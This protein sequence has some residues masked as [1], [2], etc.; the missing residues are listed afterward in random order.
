MV[1]LRRLVSSQAIKAGHGTI[2]ATPEAD[3]PFRMIL[4]RDEWVK[5]LSLLGEGVDYPNFK[6]TVH[7]DFERAMAYTEVWARMN[8]FGRRATGGA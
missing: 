7:G 1:R 6:D 2:R 3:Y 5:V 4:P 8:A